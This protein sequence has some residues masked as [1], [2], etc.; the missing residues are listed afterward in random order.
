MNWKI[1]GSSA[2]ALILFVALCI[3]A[4][5]VGDT[6]L[7]VALNFAVLVFGASLGWIVGIV[8][9]PYSRTEQQQFTALSKAL[10][11]F[12]SG[13]L[14]GKLDKLLEKL[15]DPSFALESVNGF[16][17]LAFVSGFAIAMVL[18]FV[19]RQYARV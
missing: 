11:A 6:K 13:Y 3:L 8:V 12:A 15:L 2:S 10:A 17:L 9:S 19:Y 18:T 14:V 4:F 5:I 16:R 1:V 7:S